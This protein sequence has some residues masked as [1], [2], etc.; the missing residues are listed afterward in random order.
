MTFEKLLQFDSIADIEALS[1]EEIERIL[2]PVLAL[3]KLPDDFNPIEEKL[4]A[5]KPAKV[6]KEKVRKLTKEEKKAALAE[7]LKRIGLELEDSV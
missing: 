1:D 5:D 7:E 6:A 3:T 4:E 2:G